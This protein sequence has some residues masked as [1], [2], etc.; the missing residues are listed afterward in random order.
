MMSVFFLVGE[1]CFSGSVLFFDVENK[2]LEKWD[3]V[4]IN[5]LSF[6]VIGLLNYVV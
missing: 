1:I 2:P 6:N 5:I 3:R 4:D